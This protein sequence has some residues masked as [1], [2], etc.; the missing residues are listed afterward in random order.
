MA[1]TLPRLLF[2]ALLVASACGRAADGAASGGRTDSAQPAPVASTG[3]DTAQARQAV[4]GLEAELF[5]S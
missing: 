5:H 3:R 1:R 4:L 2:P